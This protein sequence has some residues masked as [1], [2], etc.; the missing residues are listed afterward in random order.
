LRGR[1]NKEGYEEDADGWV[2]DWAFEFSKDHE[3]YL[4][5]K[6]LASKPLSVGTFMVGGRDENHVALAASLRK[7]EE[8]TG[9]RIIGLDAVFVWRNFCGTTIDAKS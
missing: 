8:K 1:E 9:Q 4:L 7:L 2:V 6:W 3:I 5:H